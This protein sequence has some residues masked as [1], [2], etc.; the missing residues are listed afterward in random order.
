MIAKKMGKKI[1]MDN[2]DTYKMDN[3]HP[4]Q[5]LDEE[6]FEKNKDRVNNVLYNFARN[7]DL[8]TTS[9][10]YLAEEYREFNENVKVLPNC[11]DPDDWYEEPSR[12]EGDKVR[13]G[14]VGSTA[15]HHDFHRIKPLLRKL[16]EDPKVQLVLM[17]LVKKTSDN[18]KVA[19]VY[20]K[21]FSFWE[22]LDNLEHME[23]VPMANYFDALDQ[24]KLDVM[25]I[26]RRENH[27]NRAK[28]NV[29]YLEASMLE[30]PVIAQSFED[31][32][33]EEI[34]STK[35]GILVENDEDWEDAVY[36]LINNKE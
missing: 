11:I 32:P 7:A 26:P 24:L 28:S 17:G 8:V 18:P 10:E 35:N 19:E 23:F 27:F 22:S 15:Y 16:D 31:G 36:T 14:L 34:E 2:D 20:D 13:V 29:K 1:V 9:T 25:L 6:G 4:F 30:I 33:Y 21:E 3:F 12:S 5:N